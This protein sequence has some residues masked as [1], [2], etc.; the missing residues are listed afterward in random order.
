MV[1]F[2]K[3]NVFISGGSSG[4]GLA[5]AKQFS[6]LGAD[7]TI[8]ARD[9][10]KLSLAVK[11]IKQYQKNK[12]QRISSISADIRDFQLLSKA[13]KPIKTP[14]DI[15]I[16]SAGIT[17]P[18]RFLELAPD[19]FSDVI[20]TNYLGTVYLTKLITPGMVEKR[21]GT[22][23]NISSLAG[24]VGIFGYTAYTPSKYAIRGF[25]YCLR[26]E[27]KPHGISVHLVLPPDTDTPQLAFERE[28]MPETT[29][30]INSS[31]GQMSAED[32]ADV[33][34]NGIKKGKFTIIPGFE[35]KIISA[36]A[37]IINHFL[38]KFAV[39]QESKLIH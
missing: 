20:R 34:I 4:I 32:V 31:A 14:V 5:L 30:K 3:K 23:V 13:Y 17:Y 27:L 12:G 7:V 9:K 39:K 18:G 29:R 15:L 19:I 10:A 1:T 35:G 21:T 22:I 28:F 38:Y 11:Q 6:T 16:N 25:S 2:E 36:F 26:S 37:P 24:L 8:L 33:I